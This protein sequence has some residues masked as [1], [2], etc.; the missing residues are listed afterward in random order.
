MAKRIEERGGF[1]KELR[2]RIAGR[3]RDGKL[4]ADADIQTP[5]PGYITSR[6]SLPPTHFPGKPAE[7]TPSTTPNPEPIRSGD[8]LAAKARRMKK[9]RE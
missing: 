5:P 8:S 1:H 6:G 9:G 4:P 2:K 7:R 3:I